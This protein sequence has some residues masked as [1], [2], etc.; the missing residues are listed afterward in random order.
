M[1]P[2]Q[3]CDGEIQVNGYGVCGH[4]EMMWE[5]YFSLRWSHSSDE[6]EAFC[7][8]NE[9]P[10]EKAIFIPVSFLLSADCYND[11]FYPILCVLL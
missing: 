10:D 11:F 8:L 9:S 1:F 5:P 3:W 7:V 4:Q 2:F 6:L